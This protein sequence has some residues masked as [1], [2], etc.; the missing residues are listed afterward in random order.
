MSSIFGTTRTNSASGAL[1]SSEFA[2]VT[3]GG[4]TTLGQDVQGT[5][6][7]QIQ[8]LFELGNPNIYWLG[9]HEQGTFNFSS[10]VGKAGFFASLPSSS[11]GEISPVSVDLLG[12]Q[13]SAA[14]GGLTVSDAVIENVNWRM[15][16][17]TLEISE[18]VSLR[19][20]TL[21]RRSA[22][23]TTVVTQNTPV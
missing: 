1:A 3:L 6:T 16:A 22:P 21:S 12:G 8:T 23:S 17:G 4:V 13:C 2:K 14:G 7:R 10:L 11:C 19:F 9:G 15:A 20:A 18:G 5:Y